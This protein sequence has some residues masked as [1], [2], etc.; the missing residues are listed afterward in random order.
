MYRLWVALALVRLDVGVVAWPRMK[1]K[2]LL[3]NSLAAEKNKVR[4]LG[5][6]RLTQLFTKTPFLC[7]LKFLRVGIWTHINLFF[8]AQRHN[9]PFHT[10]LFVQQKGLLKKYPQRGLVAFIAPLHLL[11]LPAKHVDQ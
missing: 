3:S 8:H 4:T 2:R 5:N 7:S 11:S 1:K 10:L 6:L 9:L